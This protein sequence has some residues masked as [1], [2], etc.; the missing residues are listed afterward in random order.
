VEV[1]EYSA[2]FVSL[3]IVGFG[4]LIVTAFAGRQSIPDGLEINGIRI[5]KDRFVSLAVLPL[6]DG[7]A[8]LFDAGD[9]K[10]GKA[11]LGELS[12]LGLGPEDV[13]AIFL[14][15]GHRDHISGAPLFPNAQV[16]A[17]SEEVDIAE[18]RAS[19]GG[20]IPR[21]LPVKPT[22]VKIGRTLQDGEV[23]DLGTV[24]V[25]VFAVPGHTAGCAA[26]L[27]NGVLILGDAADAGSDGRVR[28]SPWIFSKDQAQDRASL[29]R[30]ATRLAGDGCVEA[31]VFAHSGVL[32]QGIEPLALAARGW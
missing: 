5:V 25:R 23:V 14:T 31:L 13:K 10:T 16:M 2:I 30:L 11:I 19:S 28:C 20:P 17:L 6:A 1:L 24:K 21:F 9:D 32:K 7:G 29:R 26:Y 4:I 27:V 3:V 8:A 18:G 22:G 12:R 15:H